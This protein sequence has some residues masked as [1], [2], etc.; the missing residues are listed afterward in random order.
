M[1]NDFSS[2]Y[3]I[4]TDCIYIPAQ[5]PPKACQDYAKCSSEYPRNDETPFTIICDG[6]GSSNNSDFGA[7]ILAQTSLTFYEKLLKFNIED[8]DYSE[9]GE[10]VISLAKVSLDSLELNKESLDSTL[11]FSF[12]F[13]N[14]IHTFMY[15]DGHVF[16][17][18]KD[19]KFFIHRQ[20]SFNKNAPYYLNYQLDFDRNNE[21]K[22]WIGDSPIKIAFRF[23]PNDN[24]EEYNKVESSLETPNTNFVNLS[25]VET[26]IT[27]S[28]GIESF[29]EILTGRKIPPTEI[30]K[31]LINIKSKNGE[32][33]KRRVRKMMDSLAEK[34]IYNYDD[35]SVAGFMIQEKD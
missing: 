4:I 28:D 15:G 18:N 10:G 13:N 11:I 21:Y 35:V 26:Y 1:Q 2:K 27:T 12:I 34:G 8:L 24:Y 3:K 5:K 25:D 33:I 14:K 22:K 6:C 20:T 23:N 32:F 7:R 17:F 16:M 31:E 19:H 9:F 30:I 29:V